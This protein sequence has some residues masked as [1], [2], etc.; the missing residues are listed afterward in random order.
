MTDV[1]V[2]VLVGNPR[3]G[4]RTRE[5][6]VLAADRLLP[7]AGAAVVDLA[8]LGPDVLDPSSRAFGD[9]VALVSRARL[10]VVASPTYKATYTG[11]LKVFLDGFET[12]TGLEGV[13]AVPLMLG[14]APQHAL[15]PELL[16]KPL[17][18]EL[19]AT[20]P[21]P[22][23]FLG[24]DDFADGRAIDRYVGRWGRALRGSLE[25]ATAAS[26]D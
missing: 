23:L 22:G 10:L 9:A 21:A 1:P 16:L 18:V 14:G 8:A 20:T 17:L 26:D 12:G 3:A 4:S 19:G 15:A 25:A 11:L 13:V 5:A 6:G 2:T 24:A 7:G